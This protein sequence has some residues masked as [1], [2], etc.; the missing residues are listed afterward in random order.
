MAWKPPKEWEEHFGKSQSQRIYKT[1]G[2][3]YTRGDYKKMSYYDNSL[4]ATAQHHAKQTGLDSKLM[5]N[6]LRGY[7]R[8]QAIANNDNNKQIQKNRESL[9]D[10]QRKE[11][12]K[13]WNSI[14]KQIKK[15]K[16]DNGKF[17][18]SEAEKLDK[19]VKEFTA[20]TGRSVTDNPITR[21]DLKQF[22]K[23]QEVLAGGQKAVDKAKGK[24]EKKEEKESKKKDERDGA[25]GFL[26]DTVGRASKKA[27][28]WAFGKEFVDNQAKQ[29]A[30]SDNEQVK[31]MQNS[32][33]KKAETKLE[34]SG[35]I[36]GNVFGI[37][38]YLVP[39]QGAANLTSK[40]FR[41]SK[42]TKPGAKLAEKVAVKGTDSAKQILGKKVAKLGAEGTG[43]GLLLGLGDATVRESLSPNERDFKDH[44]K[45]IG[46]ETAGGAILD[47]LLTLGGKKLIDQGLTKIQ[48]PKNNKEK[49]LKLNQTEQINDSL[50]PPS[51]VAV[52]LDTTLETPTTKEREQYINSSPDPGLAKVKPILDFSVNNVDPTLPD[53]RSHIA[54]KTDTKLQS[55][56]NI[57][58]FMTTSVDDLHMLKQFDKVVE[59]VTGTKL[60]PSESSY[61]LGLNSR[62]ADQI[63]KQILTNEAVNSQG[64]VIGQSLKEV[65]SKIPKGKEVDFE[66]YLVN[67][68]AITR[69]E[70]G[71]K[72]FPDEMKMSPEKSA[73]IV[74]DYELNN[75]TFKQLADEY[76]EYNR[77]IGKAWLVDT[78]IISQETW[79]GYL[80][81]N[82][83]YVSNQ[84]LFDEM[85]KPMYNG[86]KKGFANQTDPIKKATGSQRKIISPIES[87]IENTDKYVKTAKRNEV[88]QTLIKN[89]TKNPEAF[90]G[91]AE[92]VPTDKTPQSIINELQEEGIEGFLEN[93]NKSFDQKP[94][95]THGNIVTGIID[96][97][98]VHVRIQDPDLLNA[99]TNL[100]PQAQGAVIET[101]GK[102]TRFMKTVTTGIN[103]VFTF[104]RNIMRDIPTAYVNSK[105]TNNPLTFTKDIA[106]AIIDIASNGELSRNFK[107]LG[108][109]HSSAVS[110]DIDLLAQS[111]NELLKRKPK[112][113]SVRGVKSRVN[114]GIGLIEN[115]NNL[116]E[117]APRLAEFKRASKNGDYDAKIQGIFEANDVTTNFNK[118]GTVARQADAFIPY[119]NAAI[120]GLN[121]TKRSMTDQ[122]IAFMIKGVVSLSLPT[123][124]TYA[125]NHDN[126]KYHEV[127]RHI[128]DN[129]FLVPNPADGGETFIKIAKPRELGVMFSTP[130]ERA[131]NK[132]ENDDPEAFKGFA[133]QIITNYLPPT[134]SVFKPFQDIR[135]NKNFMDAPIVSGDLARLSPE[136][137]Y[138]ART[139]EPAKFLG[140]VF[141]KSPKHIDYLASQYGGIISDLGI[142]L[143]TKDGGIGEML[144]R[145]VTADPVFNNDA[146]ND[147]YEKKQKLDT[148][149]ADFKATGKTSGDLNDELRKAYGR[150][151]RDISDLR[152]EMKS[153][154]NDESLS[155]EER[156]ERVRNIQIEINNLARTY[157]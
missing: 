6:A 134:N 131:L 39:G 123:I 90:K 124:I 135:A 92:I 146:L 21:Y 20:K 50:E 154:L 28:E 44:L 45:M 63:S 65:V 58:K 113:N 48:T 137:Q 17:I 121:K 42:A 66:D 40:A 25:L 130:L 149:E 49:S 18:D 60:K 144:K 22:Q 85:E 140:K 72:V 122:P 29:Y 47:P 61:T 80:K 69:M 36:L 156:K 26:D 148:A 104:T 106:H 76:Y 1:T 129:F 73:A 115:V 64:D 98:K 120:Q 54:S 82:P 12:K 145:Q 139:S 16:D 108:G 103:P 78:G 23:L 157:K 116:V 83:N 126:P 110:T 112:I 117:M 107:A 155:K 125:M 96:G 33:N 152:R 9:E 141:N 84:R 81:A 87:T 68:H 86:A 111:K 19:Q 11:A 10:V 13:D 38:S 99:I 24:K 59:K 15:G 136:N 71:E 14:S 151:S 100:H 30:K 53:T 75:P 101:V 67:K 8:D 127:S 109:G 88:M 51:Q 89:I 150:T 147:F 46:L 95:L 62:G 97:Q 52:G 7:F 35:D 102:L 105:T 128:K 55:K 41:L 132:L 37:G 57:D 119:L 118:R 153:I 43:A 114:Q 93:F 3:Q 138:D 5:E 94:D 142:P 32:I 56:I 133:K 31:K 74:Q 91:W 2:T 79:D 70:R 143:T 77:N 4:K 27:Q 34:K